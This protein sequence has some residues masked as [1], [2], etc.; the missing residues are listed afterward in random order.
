MPVF[1]AFT[2]QIVLK[3]KT[4]QMLL[5]L[6]FFFILEAFYLSTLSHL[7]NR[8]FSLRISYIFSMFSLLH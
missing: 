5:I 1:L 7:L 3:E 8:K 6:H 4:H 2:V